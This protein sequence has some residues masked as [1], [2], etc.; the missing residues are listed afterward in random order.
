VCPLQLGHWSEEGLKVQLKKT[1]AKNIFSINVID[2]LADLSAK[3]D[4]EYLSWEIDPATSPYKSVTKAGGTNSHIYTYRKKNIPKLIEAGYENAEY[5]PL[6]SNTMIRRP[7]EEDLEKYGCDISF[8]GSS[9]RKNARR[10]LNRILAEIDSR[11]DSDANWKE[12][13]N[14]IVKWKSSSPDWDEDTQKEIKKVLDLHGLPHEITINQDPVYLPMAIGEYR[15]FQKRVQVVKNVGD[16]FPIHVW[17]DSGWRDYVGKKGTYRGKAGHGEELTKI[18]SASRIN[19][20]INRIYQPEIV[21]MRVFDAMAC[22]SVVLT[23]DS[24]EIKSLFEPGMD[25]FLYSGREDLLLTIEHLLNNERELLDVGSR[26]REKIVDS[27]TIK[28]RLTERITSLAQY[29]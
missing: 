5:C 26:A 1:A 13:K 18:Y 3:T 10:Q 9:M 27:H 12:L 25:C 7:V 11:S 16:E 15:A 2:G 22:G 4:M 17:G 29:I 24:E 14:H 6:A 19:L 21:T 28:K 20:D 23:E 8:V